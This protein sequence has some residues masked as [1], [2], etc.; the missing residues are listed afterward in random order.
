MK[1]F[2]LA[3]LLVLCAVMP[4]QA[5]G[6]GDYFT[7]GSVSFG[8]SEPKLL[9]GYGFEAGEGLKDLGESFLF[10]YSPVALRYGNEKGTIFEIGAPAIGGATVAG[11]DTVNGSSLEFSFAV[12]AGILEVVY[13][14]I[15]WITNVEQP[16][17]GEATETQYLLLI[18]GVKGATKGKELLMTLWGMTGL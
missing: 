14:T 18:D 11:D 8:P 6:L 12:T 1:R 5:A 13:P 10:S 16:G 7:N 3:V 4:V 17:G 9:V 15:G 2:L